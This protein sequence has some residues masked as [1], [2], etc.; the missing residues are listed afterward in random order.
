MNLTSESKGGLTGIVKNIIYICFCLGEEYIM[1][2]KET[3]ASEVKSH[4]SKP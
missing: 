3:K 4:L 2:P 1:Y